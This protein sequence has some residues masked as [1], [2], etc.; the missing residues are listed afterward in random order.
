MDLH[1]KRTLDLHH[2]Q[3]NHIFNR[4][5]TNGL[6]CTH[7]GTAFTN[8]STTIGLKSKELTT[9]IHFDLNTVDEAMNDQKES[10]RIT[11]I[12][13]LKI[14]S[15]LITFLFEKAKLLKLSKKTVHISA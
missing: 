13:Y 8:Q 5:M 10:W 3:C 2:E 6:M 7:C 1:K 15:M 11:N 4:K 14:R 12:N 9:K